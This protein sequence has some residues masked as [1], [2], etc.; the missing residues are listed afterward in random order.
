M[1]GF[2]L[3]FKVRSFNKIRLLSDFF[4]ESV[5]FFWRVISIINRFVLQ[6]FWTL[7]VE[8][9]RCFAVRRSLPDWKVVLA[10]I[11]LYVDAKALYKFHDIQ[12]G[13]IYDDILRET[14]WTLPKILQIFRRCVKFENF[15]SRLRT[16]VQIL[17]Y[18]TFLAVVKSF[19]NTLCI[20]RIVC[21]KCW[22]FVENGLFYFIYNVCLEQCYILNGVLGK[23]NILI[24]AMRIHSP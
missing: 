9:L 23:R 20:A 12:V 22:H 18:F 24:L 21:R 14:F 8:L 11:L 5:K 19:A 13:L 17:G 2:V 4:F 3:R 6:K 15:Q 16:Y 1:L 10:T 7:E